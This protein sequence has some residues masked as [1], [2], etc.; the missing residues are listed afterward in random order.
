MKKEDTIDD[1]ISDIRYE[2]RNDLD[3]EMLI[4]EGLKLILD[5]IKDQKKWKNKN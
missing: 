2:L 3:L 4:K 5:K 1:M